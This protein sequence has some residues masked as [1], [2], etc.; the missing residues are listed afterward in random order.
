MTRRPHCIGLICLAVLSGCQSL[1]APVF[2][3][4]TSKNTNFT[5]DEVAAMNNPQ[6]VAARSG[7]GN[8]GQQTV[9]ATDNSQP[10][11]S[12]RVEQ[13]IQSGQAALREGQTPVQLKRARQDFQEALNLDRS[14]A[15][16]HHGIA[17]VAD[18]EEDWRTAEDH[19][20]QALRHRPQDPDFLNDLG[21]SY[22]LQNRYYESSQYLNQAIQVS[23]QHERAHI[24]LVLWSL[25][26]GDRFAAETRLSNIYSPEDVKMMLARLEDDL[27]SQD[28]DD[29]HSDAS[30]PLNGSFEDTKRL[31][32]EE[33]ERA[34][35]ARREQ[36]FQEH[37]RL[38]A[39]TPRTPLGGITQPQPR[40]IL[41]Q[42]NTAGF[43]AASDT[44][45][46][47]TERIV[48]HT[49][50]L[51]PSP[52]NVPQP[53]VAA[54]SGMTLRNVPENNYPMGS[55]PSQV[56]HVS[57]GGVVPASSTTDLS[58]YVPHQTA[59]TAAAPSQFGH[60]TQ[61]GAEAS[62]P[63]GLIQQVTQPQSPHG[64]GSAPSS[65]SMQ[66][67]QDPAPQNYQ[68]PVAGLNAGPGSLFPIGAGNGSPGAT[69]MTPVQ[70]M[71]SQVPGQPQFPGQ[72]HGGVSDQALVPGA[73]TMINGT[74]Y[75]QPQR[76]LPA[77][78]H[79]Q[80]MQQMQYDRNN[81]APM[82]QQ[83][84]SAVSAQGRPTF[85]AGGVLSPPGSSP[86]YPA[87]GQQVAGNS[88]IMQT[89]PQGIHPGGYQYRAG[90]TP[91]GQVG[92]IAAPSPL[93]AYDQQ[94]R[95]LNS[96][97]NQAIQQ[98]DGTRAGLQPVQARY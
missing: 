27:R 62:A 64:Y 78:Q 79:M 10:V 73:N 52:A 51:L 82:I 84:M 30:Q 66:Q 20:K 96:E 12:G 42:Q 41:P 72:Y 77:E 32:A 93:A 48:P 91:T 95:G 67:F 43:P 70:S 2:P 60:P 38:T 17:I 68:A 34:Q 71:G 59:S 94:L 85:G 14:N 83:P 21:Y 37:Q 46:M 47:T 88:A 97:Y 56:A 4:Q 36:S 22:L 75:Q 45:G 39:A 58:T 44:G 9:S 11:S 15:W 76:V 24:N 86:Q 55:L 7:L 5:A 13:L 26:Q 8:E 61:Y 16:A 3:W 50:Y 63:R 74:M 49:G 90:Q 65:A 35:R 23:P 54:V 87:R 98:T 81:S 92:S 31:M 40:Y 69:G 89:S 28:G 6:P 57:V 29:V 53:S 18:L 1:D 19:Y 33:R 25:K 80:Q